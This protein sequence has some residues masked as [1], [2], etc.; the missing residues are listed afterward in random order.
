MDN[1]AIS[2]WETEIGKRTGRGMNKAE[3]IK[4]IAHS[5]PALHQRYVRYF[6]D[7]RQAKARYLEVARSKGLSNEVAEQ[8]F[9]ET[10]PS[11]AR[12][13]RG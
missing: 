4:D 13:C 6:N 11:L 12:A 8:R 9:A 1:S 7:A 10:H 5:N 2:E 3:A